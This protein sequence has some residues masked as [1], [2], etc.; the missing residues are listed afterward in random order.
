M[1]KELANQPGPG[2]GIEIRERTS[3]IAVALASLVAIAGCGSDDEAT[4]ESASTTAAPQICPDIA[5][6]VGPVTEVRAT[7]DCAEVQTLAEDVLSRDDCVEETGAGAND[8]ISGEFECATTVETGGASF[9][10]VKCVSGSDEATFEYEITAPDELPGSAGAPPEPE[11]QDLASFS[12]PTGNIG[13]VMNPRFVRCDIGERSWEPPPSPASCEVDFGQGAQIS[14]QG[15]GELV[16]AGDT[17]LGTEQTLEYGQ[18]S[19]VGPYSCISAEAGITCED[20]R[21]GHG[22]FLSQ[23][24]YELY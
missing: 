7:I 2:S 11:S 8:C 9:F 17:T 24:S 21:T 4:T 15:P 19:E 23:Q 18:S 20:S 6:S 16:C 13:C 3:L 5:T 12:T 14:G 22:F 10:V 1:S